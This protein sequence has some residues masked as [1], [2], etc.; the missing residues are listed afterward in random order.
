MLRS[1]AI[2]VMSAALLLAAQAFAAD[3]ASLRPPV[4]PRPPVPTP[5]PAPAPTCVNGQPNLTPSTV[6]FFAQAGTAATSLRQAFCV[7]A[8]APATPP[9]FTGGQQTAYTWVSNQLYPGSNG[10]IRQ[11]YSSVNIAWGALPWPQSNAGCG[12]SAADF[13]AVVSQLRTEISA[14]ANIGDLFN[15]LATYYVTPLF[16]SEDGVVLSTVTTLALPNQPVTINT[17]AVLEN[18][19]LDALQNVATGKLADFSP[20]GPVAISAL[21]NLSSANNG[22]PVPN[23][24]PTEVAQLESQLPA[25]F[26]AINTQLAS[27]RSTVISDYALFSA[28]GLNSPSVTQQQ[29]T[30]LSNTNATAY[31]KQ[32]YRDLLPLMANVVFYSPKDDHDGGGGAVYTGSDA[33]AYSGITG[34]NNQITYL[35][36]AGWLWN[37]KTYYTTYAQLLTSNSTYNSGDAATGAL[38]AN[39]MLNDAIYQAVF[40]ELNFSYDELLALSGMQTK[41]Q[42]SLCQSS[43]N[44]NSACRSNNSC[45]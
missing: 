22:G 10:D 45:I 35:H 39:N 19:L 21:L 5:A 33:S 13:N 29:L 7:D 14:V 12:C 32:L 36:Y 2:A 26:Q 24:L 11:M 42:C 1:S 3:T 34:P 40:K 17:S 18:T 38:C 27:L 30:S 28:I 8:S 23:Q 16:V 41:Q 43:S 44:C 20:L 31:K 37:K 9:A 6:S 15:A 25:T 4:P